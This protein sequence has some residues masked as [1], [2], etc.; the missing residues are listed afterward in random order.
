MRKRGFKHKALQERYFQLKDGECR[1]SFLKHIHNTN[2]THIHTNTNR[3]RVPHACTHMQ[4]WACERVH[5][6]THTH[7]M[8]WESMRA[9]THKHTGNLTYWKT[10]LDCLD[11]HNPKGTISVIG[12]EITKVQGANKHGFEWFLTEHK[13]GRV[14]EFAVATS[15]NRH[16]WICAISHH[17]DSLEDQQVSSIDT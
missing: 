11:K 8:T 10:K 5:T 14:F 15:S 12:A 16:E 1:F 3:L 4:A 2:N 9:H 6:H 7:R 13:T 17:L